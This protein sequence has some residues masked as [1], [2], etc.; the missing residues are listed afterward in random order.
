MYRFVYKHGGWWLKVSTVEE[1]AEY[2]ETAQNPFARGFKSAMNCREFGRDIPGE[3]L[4]PHV[5]REGYVIGLHAENNGISLFKSACALAIQS[6]NA[7]LAELK[8]G[9]NLYFNRVGGW[10]SGKNDF[11]QWCDRKELAF[12]DFRKS[13]IKVNHTT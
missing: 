13:E 10:H 7:M 1:L 11:T 6:D 9:N 5:N 12:P 8:K 2:M 4:R 3:P